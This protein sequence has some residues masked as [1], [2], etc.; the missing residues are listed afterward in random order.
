M[1]PAERREQ[2]KAAL[3]ERILDAARRLFAV[4]GFEQVTMRRIAQDIGY[5]ATTLYL[6]FPDKQTLFAEICHHDFTALS[7]GFAALAD[8]P[9]PVDR[10][11]ALGRGYVEFALRQPHHYRLMFMV[12]LP[13]DQAVLNANSCPR[14]QGDPTQDSYALLISLVTAAI[15]AGRLRPQFR[16]PHLAGQ[17][18]WAGLHGVVALYLDKRNDPWVPWLP[19][20]QQAEAMIS[21]LM[22]GMVEGAPAT[23]SGP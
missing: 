3:R 4:E 20:P 15:A 13:N 16:D 19:L 9:D 22:C 14:K 7:A 12:P 18:L 1:T 5:S 23:G 6:H 17:V 10:I 21:A 11:T 8:I 2:E